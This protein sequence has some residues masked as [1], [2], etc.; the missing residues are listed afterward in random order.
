MIE[1]DGAV[2]SA[3]SIYSD[4]IVL[5]INIVQDILGKVFALF[6]VATVYF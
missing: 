4:C 5:F 2:A 1:R 3:V 6:N